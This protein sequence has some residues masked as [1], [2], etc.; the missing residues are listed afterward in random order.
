VTT[1]TDTVD[2]VVEATNACLQAFE[3]AGID[4]TD[5]QLD[6]CIAAYQE[7]GM[8]AVNALIADILAALGGILGG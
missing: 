5:E 3:D 4:P 6:E 8:D 7:G 1:T 2:P